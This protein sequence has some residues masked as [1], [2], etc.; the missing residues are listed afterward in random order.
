MAKFPVELS[1]VE[2]IVDG[3]N[4]LLSGP[5]GLGQNFSGFTTYEVGYLTG[6]YRAP[7]SQP[8]KRLLNVSPIDLASSEFIDGRTIKFTFLTPQST[9]PFSLGDNV[10][11]SGVSNDWYD[12]RW[13]PIGVIECTT[14]YCLV[15]TG[16]QYEP[17]FQSIGGGGTISLS[18]NNILNSTDCNSRVTVTGVTDKVFISGQLEHIFEYSGTGDLQVKIQVNRYRAFINNDPVNPDYFFEYDGTVAQKT[19][20]YS[21]SGTGYTTQTDTIFSTLLDEATSRNQNPLTPWPAYY[22]YIMEIEASSETVE[23][24]SAEFG[25]RS[26]SVQVVKL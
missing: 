8:T 17:P 23:M 21:V 5:S 7:F 6:N 15:R 11:V 14:T 22:W 12:Y 19:Y 25:L 13:T 4:Y 2:G 1:D 3:V 10:T 24:V 18:C 9:I 26:L 16:S 20:N